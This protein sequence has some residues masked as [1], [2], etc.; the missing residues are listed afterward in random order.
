MK[1]LLTIDHVT[2]QNLYDALSDPVFVEK[3][4][5]AGQRKSQE[6]H[7]T[8]VR[9]IESNPPVANMEHADTGLEVV[10]GQPDHIG[11]RAVRQDHGVAFE[12]PLQGVQVV[13]QAGGALV[14]IKAAKSQ[15]GEV[16]AG[17]E[18]YTE[19]AC[20]DGFYVMPAI[21]AM[22]EQSAIVEHET[23]AP[24]LYVMK[25]KDFD[26]AIDMQNAVP[27]GL[28]SCVFSNNVRESETFLSSV[29]SDCGIANVNIGTSGAEIGGAFGGEKE[30]GGGRESGS[31][32]W[33]A[34]MRR[35]T[36]TINY[37]DQMPLAQGVVFEI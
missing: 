5:K 16:L 35:Q 22:P 9:F 6:L 28:S 30:T 27:Q 15:G 37:S 19:G 21:I 20:A 8:A 24:I 14:A 4:Y 34:Y 13:T 12:D 26:D 32:A 25:Y 7:D 17:G 31:D 3:L 10:A 36:Q 18:R 23:F 1:Q 29:G 11:V 33:K 2:E